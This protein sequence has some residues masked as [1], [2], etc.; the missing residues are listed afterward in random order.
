M[1]LYF[2]L[3]YV[4]L[5]F[6]LSVMS[7]C[8]S[9]KTITESVT[10]TIYKNYYLSENVIMQNII[11][12]STNRGLSYVL[13]HRIIAEN[14]PQEFLNFAF[15]L[16]SYFE[17]N[18]PQNLDVVKNLVK[19]YLAAN[20]E[21]SSLV[22]D[23]SYDPNYTIDYV[24]TM[25]DKRPNEHFLLVTNPVFDIN[26]GYVIASLEYGYRNDDI[27]GTGFIRLYRYDEGKLQYL[28]VVVEKEIFTRPQQ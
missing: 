1:K 24:G 3:I 16:V 11:K 14:T 12:D 10:T 20:S 19:K 15:Q 23:V 6:M 8:V 22:L 2:S 17:K 26:T 13:E 27:F 4:A 7:S 9:Y 25:L 28:P 18:D 5:V 21:N